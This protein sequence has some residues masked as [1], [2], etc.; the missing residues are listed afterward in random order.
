MSKSIFRYRSLE[1]ADREI[2]AIKNLI[3]YFSKPREYND[4]NE[5]RFNS[6]HSL[7]GQKHKKLIENT[8]QSVE[9]YIVRVT[10]TCSFCLE[11]E[12]E[13]MWYM[14]ADGLKGFCLELDFPSLRLNGNAIDGE[15]AS[16]LDVSKKR[17]QK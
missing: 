17:F 11:S 14:Y 8:A 5:F 1:N 15:T 2:D 4:P 6:I 9:R 3:L 16:G 12:N 7:Y 13:R 10:F